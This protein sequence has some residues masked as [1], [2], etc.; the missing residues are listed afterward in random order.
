MSVM[1]TDKRSYMNDD[2]QGAVPQKNG[3]QIVFVRL[4]ESFIGCWMNGW[5]LLADSAFWIVKRK[6]KDRCECS[7]FDLFSMAKRAFLRCLLL[8]DM[9]LME[10]I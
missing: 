10:Y 9:R 1:V 8:Y 5:L 3:R 2:Y 4:R 6:S 7:S